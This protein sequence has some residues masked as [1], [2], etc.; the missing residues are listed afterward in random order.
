MSFIT[1][2]DEYLVS[3]CLSFP[4]LLIYQSFSFLHSV[5]IELKLFWEIQIL[6]QYLHNIPN[7]NEFDISLDFANTAFNFIGGK[8]Y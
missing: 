7:A 3:L 8:M 5:I 6:L 1:E 2:L 4:N